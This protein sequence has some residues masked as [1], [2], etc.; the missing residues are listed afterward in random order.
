MERKMD[1]VKSL[2]EEAAKLREIADRCNDAP[3]FRERLLELA[4]KCE[5]VAMEFGDKLERL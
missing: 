3:K 4:E 2:R 1:R 5:R